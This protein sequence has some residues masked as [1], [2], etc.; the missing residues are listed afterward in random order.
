MKSHALLILFVF[1]FLGGTV[2]A[3]DAAKAPATKV[4]WMTL[5]EAQAAQK[6]EP[7]KIMMDVYTKWCGP[8][9]MMERS[10][11]SDPALVKYVNA[12]YYPVKFNGEG[13]KDVVFNGKKYSNPGFDS[14]RSPNAR[15]SAHQLTRALQVTGY[16][17]VLVFDNELK[18]VRK[19]VG[20]RYADTMLP[21]LQSL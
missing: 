21:I 15:N 11:F 12:N 17:T 1:A 6:K 8:C 19:L 9:K 5:E 18:L 16:P 4:N 7:R 13:G 2:F 10:T 20:L 3:Q 14:N